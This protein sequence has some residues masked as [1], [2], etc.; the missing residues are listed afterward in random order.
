MSRYL[1]TCCRCG[2][3]GDDLKCPVDVTVRW[4]GVRETHFAQVEDPT[5][6]AADPET[7]LVLW[8]SQAVG[9]IRTVGKLERA[10]A[11]YAT[12]PAG[13]REHLENDRLDDLL[14]SRA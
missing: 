8:L 1:A 7:G 3:E 5:S 10:V 11:A 14:G 2:T 13:I 4:D 12:L 9:E 6:P